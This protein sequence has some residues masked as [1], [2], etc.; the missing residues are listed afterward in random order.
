MQHALL[1]FT[2]EPEWSALAT[3]IGRSFEIPSD[4][5]AVTY[6]NSGETFTI[7]TQNALETFYE[8]HYK[9][10]EPIR[11]VVKVPGRTSRLLFASYSS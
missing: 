2:N 5:V 10:G 8:A 3:E 9:P 6:I 4:K 7:R 11:F 1:S